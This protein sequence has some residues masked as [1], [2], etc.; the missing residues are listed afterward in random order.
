MKWYI[1]IFLLFSFFVGNQSNAQDINV[2]NVNPK[3]Y[4]ASPPTE[5]KHRINFRP[6]DT[7][8]GIKLTTIS[9]PQF[10]VVGLNVNITPPWTWAPRPFYGMKPGDYEKL[11]GFQFGDT[12]PCMYIK[13]IQ[14][15]SNANVGICGKINDPA[16]PGQQIDRYDDLTS[17]TIQHLD[18]IISDILASKRSLFNSDALAQTIGSEDSCEIIYDKFFVTKNN[19]KEDYRINLDACMYHCKNPDVINDKYKTLCGINDCTIKYGNSKNPSNWCKYLAT[20][21][22]SGYGN[23]SPLTQIYQNIKSQ[24]TEGFFG[25][26]VEKWKNGGLAST[27]CCNKADLMVKYSVADGAKFTDFCSHKKV[28]S[29]CYQ[30]YVTAKKIHPS[31]CALAVKYGGARNIPEARENIITRETFGKSIENYCQTYKKQNYS[32]FNNCISAY[33]NGKGR[34][35]EDCCKAYYLGILVPSRDGINFP[36]ISRFCKIKD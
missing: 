28:Q 6:L 16:N 24:K 30:E 11:M 27:E 34:V 17:N 10:T 29:L 31:C 3:E 32:F 26:C 1:Y 35:T 21:L 14:Y 20:Q 36:A 8:G 5:F 13:G 19:I 22:N 7:S 12:D 15:N 23:S 9:V 2:D 18:K 4:L 33:N 25:E